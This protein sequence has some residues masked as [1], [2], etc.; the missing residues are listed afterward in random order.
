MLP[1]FLQVLCSDV[2]YVAANGRRRVQSQV[3]IL[4]LEHSTHTAYCR[5]V[6][7]SVY[8]DKENKLLCQWVIQSCCPVIVMWCYSNVCK[9]LP[10]WWRVWASSCWWFFHRWC[11]EQTGWSSYYQVKE[12]CIV[13]YQWN[14]AIGIGFYSKVSLWDQLE[15]TIKRSHL[16]QR[17][18]DRW[19][20][21]PWGGHACSLGLSPRPYS[22]SSQKPPSPP[23]SVEKGVGMGVNAQYTVFVL[24]GN[25][26]IH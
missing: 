20:W 7:H 3:Q 12:R 22:P 4:L 26:Y 5:C 25:I 1:A 18:T 14:I 10:G 8:N 21:G 17:W 11:P 6:W 19:W 16:R 13:R 2:H 23:L 24:M 9:R 15:S